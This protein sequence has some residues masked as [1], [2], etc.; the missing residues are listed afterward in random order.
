LFSLQKRRLRGDLVALYNYLKGGCSEVGVSLF[1][2]VTGH[3]MRGNGLKAWQGRF[4]LDIRKNFFTKSVVRHQ[5]ML[6]REV[7]ES[8]PLGVFKRCVDLVLRDLV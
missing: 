8:P 7:G 2:Q 6:P 4:T 5:N 3:R 1:F